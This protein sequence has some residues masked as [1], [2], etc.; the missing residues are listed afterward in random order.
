M[1]ESKCASGPVIICASKHGMCECEYSDV[2]VIVMCE[3]KRA[4]DRRCASSTFV[5]VTSFHLVSNY[6]RL[7]SARCNAVLHGCNRLRISNC[8]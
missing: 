7:S 5:L 2:R 4:S 8:R 3:S 6:C 1:C